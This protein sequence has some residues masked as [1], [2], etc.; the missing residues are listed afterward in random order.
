MAL[1]G[2]VSPAFL[3]QR[4]DHHRTLHPLGGL[5]GGHQGR[6]VVPVHRPQV[7]DAHVLEHHAGY[8]QLLEAALCPAD[9]ADGAV[10]PLGALEGIVDS[11]FQVQIAGGRADAV[12]IFGH[13]PHVLGDG[14][15]VVVQDDDE[16]R[17]QLGGV[18]QGLIGH[19]PG[20][21]PVPDHRYNRLAAACDLPGLHQPQPRGQGGGAV[22]CVEDVAFAFLAL[23]EAAEAMELA[24]GLEPVLPA[25]EDLVGVGLMPHVPDD[26][27][28]REVQGQVQGHGQLHGPQVR[29]QMP[30]RDADRPY[31]EIPDL[32]C[33]T[34]QVLFPYLLDIVRLSNGLQQHRHPLPFPAAFLK[35]YP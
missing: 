10:P 29:P 2:P 30:S 7:G 34:S 14:H 18:V 19:A 26:F 3:R 33:Q 21:R 23:G 15:V 25:G 6:D 12:E 9:A 4:V 17:L 28:L 5:D 1:R 13:A 35:S 31:Q 27:V 11:L 24:Q 16:V 8:H 20:Q 32:L 22:A